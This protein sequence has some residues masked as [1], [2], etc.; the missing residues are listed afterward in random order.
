MSHSEYE[1]PNGLDMSTLAEE[2]KHVFQGTTVIAAVYVLGSAVT[3]H[4]RPDSDIDIALLPMDENG[5]SM[6]ARL[7]I[8]GRLEARL[9]RTVDVGVITARNLVY[10]REAIL[11]GRRIITLE[12]DYA[13]ATET[14]LLG[15]YLT[16]RQDR[17]VVEESYRAPG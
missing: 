10:A 8:A 5:I 13:E 9:K 12:E 15:C 7:A 16:F 4:L 11:N 3:G 17:Q 14:R 2:L 6:Q 1:Q